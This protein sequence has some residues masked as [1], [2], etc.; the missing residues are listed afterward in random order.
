M[1]F[2]A[3]AYLYKT[4]DS[5]WHDTNPERD[6]PAGTGSSNYS[7][8]NNSAIQSSNNGSTL[9]TLYTRGQY[10]KP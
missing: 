7:I 4:T 9:N 8:A 6:Y 3:P 5:K 2:K 1:W 10:V